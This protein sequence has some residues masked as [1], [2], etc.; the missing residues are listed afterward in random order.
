MFARSIFGKVILVGAVLAATLPASAATHIFVGG[1]FGSGYRPWGW[2]YYDPYFYGPYPGIVSISPT[3]GSVKLDIKDKGAAV[4]LDGS[5]AGVV[6][7]LKTLH[8]RQGS[9]DL[10][11]REGDR[12]LYDS[13]IYVVNGKTLHIH[14]DLPPPSA[15]PNS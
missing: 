6:G 9:Y 4:F 3:T 7:E 1:R 8:L 15:A 13:R 11:V 12:D 2:G 14:P 5:Y 10:E